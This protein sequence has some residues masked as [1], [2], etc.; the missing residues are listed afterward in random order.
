V[1]AVIGQIDDAAGTFA[2]KAAEEVAVAAAPALSAA[3]AAAAVPTVKLGEPDRPRSLDP[4]EISRSGPGGKITLEDLLGFVGLA[5]ADLARSGPAVRK[6]VADHGIDPNAIP[7]SGRDGRLTKEDVQNFLAGRAADS[8]DAAVAEAAAPS[9]ED[10]RVKRVRM[11]R[12]RRTIAARLKDAQNTAAILTTF[13]EVDMS[14]IR[15]LRTLH[16]DAFEKRHGVKL[17]FTSFFVK[18]CVAAL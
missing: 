16:R 17:G 1:G 12:M 4:A 8:A 9:V 13:N 7:A 10:P 14:A 2:E 18:A 3:P 15:E 5:A 6:L 11:T